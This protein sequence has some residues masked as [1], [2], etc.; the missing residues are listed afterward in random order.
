[1]QITV[2][3]MR[4]TFYNEQNTKL[5]LAEF[6]SK[7][8]KLSMGDYCAQFEY[9]FAKWHGLK[10]GILFNSGASANLALLQALKNIGV[11]KNGD[12]VA[13]SAV[14]WATNVMPIIQ[15]GFVPIPIDGTLNCGSKDLLEVINQGTKIRCFFITNA[16]GFVKD[17]EKI[18]E[19]CNLHGIILLEDNCEAL[20][21]RVNSGKLTGT[22][23][24]A[25]T[26]SFFVGH[27]LSTIEGGMILTNSDDIARMARIVR[28]NGWDRNL[29]LGDQEELR[30][31]HRIKNEFD[32][33][34]TFYELAFNMRPTEITGFLGLNQMQY[35]DEI[36]RK[37]NENYFL[38]N[39]H[40]D[41][42]D[43]V[44]INTAGIKTLSAFAIP[45]FFY[46][47]ET[48]KIY[49]RKFQDLGIETRPVIAGNIT[50]HPFW[51]KN[52]GEKRALL[53]ADFTQTHGFYFANRPDFT[54]EEIEIVVEA[55][56]SK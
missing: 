15:M 9:E 22:F 42:M 21:T 40:A 20:G 7:A 28:A 13:F 44:T 27:H 41:P 51:K 31:I 56:G 30:T 36:I 2:P 17:I 49:L 29:S 23:S 48:R 18:R 47:D 14:T 53:G 46:T 10:H 37:R 8:K 43:I 52:I 33:K 26:F 16:L 39:V 34:Y 38:I 55:L 35:L 1:M 50:S 19:I 5:N 45:L 4:N 6:I 12:N 32:A 25:S 54:Q 24:A 3:L 11:L